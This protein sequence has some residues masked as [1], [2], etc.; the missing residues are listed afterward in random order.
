MAA[1]TGRSGSPQHS[2]QTLIKIRSLS[3]GAS[4]VLPIAFRRRYND[5]SHLVLHVVPVG[6]CRDSVADVLDH[7]AKHVAQGNAASCMSLRSQHRQGDADVDE[8]WHH[9]RA[10]AGQAPFGGSLGPSVLRAHS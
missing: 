6:I 9:V 7:V 4:G 2:F 10:E 1:L 8:A 5:I 3:V